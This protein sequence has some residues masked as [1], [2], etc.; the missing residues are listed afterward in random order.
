MPVPSVSE[1]D[2]SAATVVFRQNRRL[3]IEAGTLIDVVPELTVQIVPAKPFSGRPPSATGG[4]KRV[5]RQ[6]PVVTP[7]I[8]SSL[9]P[10]SV[11]L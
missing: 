7:G 5:S 1:P 6:V 3:A 11:S 4:L 8:G 9:M 2:V 10:P